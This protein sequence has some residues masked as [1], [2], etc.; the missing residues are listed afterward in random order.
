MYGRKGRGV[1]ESRAS[2]LYTC[3]GRHDTRHPTPSLFLVLS[4]VLY[5][6]VHRSLTE[7]PRHAEQQQNSRG[8]ET[9]SDL[10]RDIPSN[11]LNWT[12]LS[13]TAL[14]AR[15]KGGK[16]DHRLR[17]PRPPFHFKS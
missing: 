10:I 15:G 1:R 7:W 2:A 16:I 14:L 12:S 6:A 17:R 8:E 3:Q 11:P 5:Y 4:L 13:L 9:Q